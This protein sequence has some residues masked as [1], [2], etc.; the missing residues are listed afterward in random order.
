MYAWFCF[1]DVKND[2]SFLEPW[3]LSVGRMAL[4][5]CG[6]CFADVK[7]DKSFLE[8]RWVV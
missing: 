4:D 1:A 5:V 2:K 7:N 6:V 3:D 8:L